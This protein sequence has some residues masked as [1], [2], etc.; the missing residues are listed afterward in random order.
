MIQELTQLA[1]HGVRMFEQ[2][3]MVTSNQLQ[4][5]ILFQSHISAA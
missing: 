5:A 2:G 1:W 3:F 4:E